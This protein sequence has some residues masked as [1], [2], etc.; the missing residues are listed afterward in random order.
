MLLRPNISI[1]IRC[2]CILATGCAQTAGGLQCVA[3][4][5]TGVHTEKGRH[6]IGLLQARIRG[7]DV[8]RAPRTTTG[9]HGRLRF[10]AHTQ[11]LPRRRSYPAPRHSHI[12]APRRRHRPG[13]GRRVGRR[14][15]SHPYPLLRGGFRPQART[16]PRS[17]RLDARDFTHR[18][19]RA[20]RDRV[21]WRHDL[22][23]GRESRQRPQIGGCFARR[24]QPLRSREWTPC[25]RT[26]PQLHN[27]GGG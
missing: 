2:L 22:L 7:M 20:R 5:A 6:G 13:V 1:R 3:D 4:C 26:H 15:A 12:Q 25:K 10:P 17:S 16:R 14:A 8:G 19:R 18:R 24:P 27:Q 9:E 23:A 21:L 11:T